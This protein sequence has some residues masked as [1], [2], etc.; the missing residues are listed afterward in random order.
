MQVYDAK[1]NV[2]IIGLSLTVKHCASSS[3]SVTK[4]YYTGHLWIVIKEG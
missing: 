3:H 2:I 4:Y 1:T